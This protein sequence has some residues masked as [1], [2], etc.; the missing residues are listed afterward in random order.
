M[1]F[2]LF[3]LTIFSLFKTPYDFP[4]LSQK[5]SWSLIIFIG[6]IFLYYIGFFNFLKKIDTLNKENFQNNKNNI[7]T[8]IKRDISRHSIKDKDIISTIK[9]DIKI[10]QEKQRKEK[11]QEKKKQINFNKKEKKE[12][13]KKQGLFSKIVTKLSDN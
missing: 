4:G 2:G 6:L 9:E 11:N 13:R 1:L 3:I 7:K 5:A 8:E 12:K 10:Q